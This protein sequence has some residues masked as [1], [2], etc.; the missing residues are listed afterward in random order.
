MHDEA[1]PVSLAEV[2]SAARTSVGDKAHT[3]GVLAR[4]GVPILGG[5]VVPASA[6]REFVASAGLA[7]IVTAQIDRRRRVCARAEEFWDSAHRIRAAFL[8]APMPDSIETAILGG[9]GRVMGG[10]VIV[11]SSAAH[12]STTSRGLVRMHDSVAGVR[13]S[14]QLLSAIR[15]VWAS[16]FSDRALLYAEELGLDVRTSAMAVIIQPLL[17]PRASGVVWSR[18]PLDV[19]HAVAEVAFGNPADLLQGSSESFRWVV[20]R[21]HLHIVDEPSAEQH[22]APPLQRGEVSAAVAH[23]VTAEEVLGEPQACEFVFTPDGPLLLEARSMTE[24][25]DDVRR[26]YLAVRLPEGRLEARRKRIEGEYLPAMWSE[27]NALSVVDLS[28]LSDNDLVGEA[29]RRAEAV[30]HWRHVYRTVLA[31]FAHGQRLF[32]EYYVKVML[33]NDPFEFI[34]L[35]V[36]TPEEYEYRRQILAELGIEPPGPPPGGGARQAAEAVFMAEVPEEEREHAAWLLDLARASWRMRDDDNLY[37]D[38]V[39]YEARRAADEI[40]SRLAAA[41]GEARSVLGPASREQLEAASRELREL[42]SAERAQRAVAT[43]A[44]IAERPSELIGDAAAP[45]RAT[46]PARV[47]RMLQDAAAVSSDE[48][49]VV[50]EMLPVVSGFAARAAGI[51]EQRGGMFAHGAVLAREHGVPCVTGVCDAS[52]VIRDGEIVTVDGDRGV[53]LFG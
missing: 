43:S 34:E 29:S 16:L 21:R 42:E 25:P 51:V 10:P 48:I 32:G 37:L 8:R 41:P 3:L 27:A 45:G 44:E 28:V 52:V 1:G 20:D 6:Y 17:E 23:A 22:E 14:R 15:S 50:A 49:V 30:A 36:R 47:V 35:L 18:H 19:E 12:L 31:P 9:A 39:E 7:E 11:R 13:G 40:D 2:H 46:G 26:D 38:R 24:P 5:I 33:P 53:L 4:A